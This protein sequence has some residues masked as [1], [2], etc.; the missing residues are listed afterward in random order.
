M[1]S[2]PGQS[3]VAPANVTEQSKARDNARAKRSADLVRHAERL[4]RCSAPCVLRSLA[5]DVEAAVA[6]VAVP[7]APPPPRLY[8]ALMSHA[9]VLVGAAWSRAAALAELVALPRSLRARARV[10]EQA[11]SALASPQ[12]L[13]VVVL[14]LPRSTSIFVCKAWRTMR[15]HTTLRVKPI[16]CSEITGLSVTAIV[17]GSPRLRAVDLSACYRVPEEAALTL[18]KSLPLL[19]S[20]LFPAQALSDRVIISLAQHCPRLTVVNFSNSTCSDDA[21]VALAACP[22]LTCVQFPDTNGELGR[23]RQVATLTAPPNPQF[24]ILVS[25]RLR[26]AAETSK[27]SPHRTLASRQQGWWPLRSA[28][29]V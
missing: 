12:S 6:L 2:S 14:L 25:L 29:L 10:V 11:A 22:K 28:F 18:T 3:D 5:A 19:E 15:N 16:Q 4:L 7:D 20:V 26:R 21:L 24:P 1:S 8:T 27:P 9:N 23:P 17:N 13:N